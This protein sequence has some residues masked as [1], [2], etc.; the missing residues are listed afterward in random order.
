MSEVKA[1][2]TTAP[3]S[4]TILSRSFTRAWSERVSAPRDFF[5]FE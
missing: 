5:N 1:M 4:W 2:A 3:K